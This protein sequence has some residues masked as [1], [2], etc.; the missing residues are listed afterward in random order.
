MSIGYNYDGKH[1][2]IPYQI[3]EENPESS[4]STYD[5]TERGWKR[6]TSCPSRLLDLVDIKYLDVFDNP[7]PVKDHIFEISKLIEKSEIAELMPELFYEVYE[8]QYANAWNDFSL[9]KV[10]AIIQ[11][12]AMTVAAGGA[13]SALIAG[14]SASWAPYAAPFVFAAVYFLLSWANS[15]EQ[16]RVSKA[17]N[18]AI[19]YYPSDGDF[20]EPTSL[21]EKTAKDRLFDDSLAAYNQGHPGAYYT[22]VVGGKPGDM[23]RGELMVTPPHSG[24]D[25]KSLIDAYEEYKDAYEEYLGNPL[26]E[27]IT[28]ELLDQLSRNQKLYN[29][30]LASARNSV[31]RKNLDYFILSSELPALNGQEFYSFNSGFSTSGDAL[32]NYYRYNTLGYLESEI[33]V[34][35]GGELDAIRPMII[36]GIPQYRY[37]DTGE[38]VV[39]LTQ[40]LSPL[41]GPIVVSKE[42]YDQLDIEDAKISVKTRIDYLSDEYTEGINPTDLDV[43][44]RARYQAKIPI[45]EG[46]F[47][48][49]ISLVTIDLLRI[50][51]VKV[52]E[53]PTPTL[54]QTTPQLTKW[55][56]EKTYEVLETV[57]LD[58]DDYR[59]EGGTLY[60]YDTLENS[61][62][63]G[64]VDDYIGRGSAGLS[65]ILTFDDYWDGETELLFSVNINFPIIIPDTLTEG[66][67]PEESI[68]A[69]RIVLDTTTNEFARNSLAQ[70]TQHAINDYFNLYTVASTNAMSQ[71]ELDFTIEVTFWSTLIST[72][73][74]L[75]ISIYAQASRAA[76]LGASIDLPTIALKQL[77]ALST[78]PI[79]EIIEEVYVDSFIEAWIEGQVAINGGD[80]RLA[81]F[82]SMLV[83]S[84]REASNTGLDM[85]VGAF[86]TDSTSDLQTQKTKLEQDIKLSWQSLVSTETV[87]GLTL[88]ALSFASGNVAFGM[89]FLG[90]TFADTLGVPVEEYARIQTIKQALLQV[91][92][93]I[94]DME[95]QMDDRQLF[96]EIIEAVSQPGIIYSTSK[97]TTVSP[98]LQGL[99]SMGAMM[100]TAYYAE[101]LQNN[102]ITKETQKQKHEAIKIKQKTVRAIE[103]Q[104]PLDEIDSID[105][106]KVI[107]R[108]EALAFDPVY[109][110]KD[111]VR[112]WI[113]PLP[114]HLSALGRDMTLND[115]LALIGVLNDPDKGAF[116]NGRE[117]KDGAE[118]TEYVVLDGNKPL[119]EAL[120]L[121]GYDRSNLFEQYSDPAVE[122]IKIRDY[123]DNYD[124]ITPY[125]YVTLSSDQ[126]EP[127]IATDYIKAKHN[128]IFESEIINTAFNDPEVQEQL[129][130]VL[131]EVMRPTTNSFSTS[132]LELFEM[133]NSFTWVSS[134]VEFYYRLQLERSDNYQ[135]AATPADK[136]AINKKFTTYITAIKDFVLKPRFD[137]TFSDAKGKGFEFI[138]QI[139]TESIEYAVLQQV[140][141]IITQNGV[142]KLDGSQLAAELKDFLDNKFD[143]NDFIKEFNK[144]GLKSTMLRFM[145]SMITGEKDLGLRFDYNDVYEIGWYRETFSFMYL[146]SPFLIQMF[147][148]SDF[149]SQITYDSAGNPEFDFLKLFQTIAFSP[150]NVNEDFKKLLSMPLGRVYD[151]LNN[152]IVGAFSTLSKQNFRTTDL[153]QMYVEGVAYLNIAI[154]NSKHADNE[155]ILDSIAIDTA[156][157]I[158]APFFKKIS[159]NDNNA[160]IEKQIELLIVAS[161]LGDEGAV[162]RII[163]KI[164]GIRDLSGLHTASSA[165]VEGEG[166]TKGPRQMEFFIEISKLINQKLDLETI[167]SSNLNE[168]KNKIKE[169]INDKDFEKLIKDTIALEIL[170]HKSSEKQVNDAFTEIFEIFTKF[171]QQAGITDTTSGAK[172]NTLL[173]MDNEG[174]YRVQ[175]SILFNAYRR[176]GVL[177][178]ETIL[179]QSNLFF[180]IRDNN[181][182][183]KKFSSYTDVWLFD[184][185]FNFKQSWIAVRDN[186]GKDGLMLVDRAIMD[187]PSS[188]VN[189]IEILEGA[190]ISDRSGELL[191]GRVFLDLDDRNRYQLSTMAEQ[192]IADH[193]I[194]S[195]T[196]HEDGDTDIFPGA[197]KIDSY[198]S[199][200]YVR[201]LVWQTG[202][203]FCSILQDVESNIVP[204]GAHKSFFNI[205][206]ESLRLE[207]KLPPIPIKNDQISQTAEQNTVFVSNL[208]AQLS[209][210]TRPENPDIFLL[211]NVFQVSKEGQTFTDSQTGIE[212]KTKYSRAHFNNIF[213]RMGLSA[214][215]LNQMTYYSIDAD[216]KTIWNKNPTTGKLI[217][218][219]DYWSSWL[220]AIKNAI[221]N[222]HSSSLPNYFERFSFLSSVSGFSSG[223]KLIM[224]VDPSNPSKFLI[225]DYQIIEW[226]RDAIVEAFG[227]EAFTLLDHGVISFSKNNYDYVLHSR[228]HQRAS[229]VDSNHQFFDS[230]LRDFGMGT[231]IDQR[232]TALAT[233]T[234]KALRSIPYNR[235]TVFWASNLILGHRQDLEILFVD[236]NGNRDPSYTKTLVTVNDRSLM[237]ELYSNFPQIVYQGRFL[238]YNREILSNFFSDYYTA[239]VPEVYSSGVMYRGT[240]DSII[241]GRQLLLEMLWSMIFETV[242]KMDIAGIFPSQTLDNTYAQE[243]TRDYAMLIFLDILYHPV[244]YQRDG[245]LNRDYIDLIK[246][247]IIHNSGSIF[248]GSTSSSTNNPIFDATNPDIGNRGLEIPIDV[249][250]FTPDVLAKIIWTLQ[251]HSLLRIDFTNSIKKIEN[252]QDKIKDPIIHLYTTL[253]NTLKN[254]QS[255]YY[256]VGPDAQP[257]TDF[258]ISFYRPYLGGMSSSTKLNLQFSDV[259]K[260]TISEID[261]TNEDEFR[262]KIAAV[263]FYMVKYIATIS[264]KQ[265]FSNSHI[266]VLYANLITILEEEYMKQNFFSGADAIGGK[267]INP[268]NINA[269]INSEDFANLPSEYRDDGFTFG[270]T[271]PIYRFTDADSFQVWFAELFNVMA[272]DYK[273]SNN[274]YPT[275]S[276]NDLLMLK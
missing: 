224:Q 66:L 164:V 105:A 150:N 89:G 51:Y 175:W 108:E 130:R 177:I 138:Q 78:A 235:P 144:K 62:F 129:E 211:D 87:V 199:Y 140:L 16:A 106:T 74:L 37:I 192:E 43:F 23:Y 234:V 24:G 206:R 137:F 101:T 18:D 217:T 190:Y 167:D 186:T 132:H 64:F 210:R 31:I 259:S 183:R 25:I 268:N 40:P 22:T 27:P 173:V 107:T 155:V 76:M 75:P 97:G 154:K 1:D 145:E 158:F 241:E 121:L 216:G 82:L 180:V 123:T 111:G 179:K 110:D 65:P 270:T 182:V 69:E 29:A 120:D 247:A 142:K 147:F 70:T 15:E 194:D 250:R 218:E 109:E 94:S 146:I 36:N 229:S 254:Y 266:N 223:D 131:N 47:A 207:N 149:Q 139:L 134:A 88:A 151:I 242:S 276:P 176:T 227:Y 245:I 5:I 249:A 159:D 230:R 265:G 35:S 273:G 215:L 125:S 213:K 258:S 55:H 162:G 208:V 262:K 193:L 56:W 84:L 122:C 60:F 252:I 92:K 172:L 135:A 198:F 116:Y 4:Y 45:S 161:K 187:I 136:L 236:E 263:V 251:Y 156:S 185:N 141:D 178:D 264:V 32:I 160:E 48:Y 157:A 261:P 204:T 9:I 2:F 91:D 168:V 68:V 118:I 80:E 248:L 8:R 143:K 191:E 148:D 253:Y 221:N 246:N 269:W 52:Y 67:S 226:V 257:R 243:V 57:T 41:Y 12:I 30:F 174:R 104:I 28:Q 54:F 201:S 195:V 10:G 202:S 166:K 200:E 61:M 112:H 93:Q 255:N 203:R 42:N 6:P 102:I 113:Q 188:I 127:I 98:N 219:K 267:L 58:S 59:L 90:G 85:V 244:A 79:A 133:K 83:T 13:S 50:V 197:D 26:E 19:T 72:A 205:I 119:T 272:R 189:E 114:A 117:L 238:R 20:S 212:V 228:S 7:V 233:K 39:D 115:F 214:N 152:D 209:R 71:A 169:Y 46:D 53:A 240:K 165:L 77:A 14:V 3:I 96:G 171:L 124:E 63:Y 34:I 153:L 49:D 220:E 73:I 231:L 128:T 271:F 225:N 184:L 17:L 232:K 44:E 38:E 11:Q 126:L 33:E 260:N 81:R 274:I 100:S 237:A 95:G 239:L 170:G 275:I 196:P 222:P 103:R 181:G 21:S 163:N 256:A 99:A 86:G